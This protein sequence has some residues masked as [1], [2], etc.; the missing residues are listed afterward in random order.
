MTEEKKGEAGE[1][2]E[3]LSG[4]ADILKQV[5]GDNRPAPSE[6]TDSPA[7]EATDEEDATT[8][9]DAL[10]RI[11]NQTTDDQPE[12]V[13]EEPAPEAAEEEPAPETTTPEEEP[14][15]APPPA[16]SSPPPASTVAGSPKTS[17]GKGRKTKNRKPATPQHAPGHEELLR[18]Q[19]LERAEV[20][21]VVQVYK[22]Y[23]K[24]VLTA[25]VAVCLV[26]LVAASIKSA[27]Q[28]KLREADTALLRARSV[29]DLRAVADNYPSTP[30]APL[31]LMGVARE[32]FN[33]GRTDEAAAIYQRVLKEYGT[34]EWAL[35]A[36][37]ALIVCKE[38]KGLYDEAQRLYA[39]FAKTHPDSWLKPKAELDRGRCLENLNR[40]DEARTVYEDVSANY[41]D[42]GWSRLADLNLRILKERT[43]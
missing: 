6:P 43:P 11:L 19:A 14:V 2:H 13:E 40:I 8:H 21:E 12:A 22:K 15:D 29:E 16:P 24:P 30:S 34:G 36:E 10:D 42:S 1:S 41:A 31:A 28:K 32:T 38:N 9:L 35:P 39:E 20:K 4:H 25:L 23:A 26:V 37:L 17:A 18:K 27:K 7:R 5:L 3:F 33:A